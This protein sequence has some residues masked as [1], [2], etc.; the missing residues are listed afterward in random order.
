MTR[1]RIDGADSMARRCVALAPVLAALLLGGC[2]APIGADRVPARAA[3][4]QV[5]ANASRTGKPSADTVSLLHRFD[6]AHLDGSGCYSRQL[7]AGW[8]SEVKVT[9]HKTINTP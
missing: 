1:Y 3:Y 4:A 5:E 6:L 8:R 9:K 7:P 2:T